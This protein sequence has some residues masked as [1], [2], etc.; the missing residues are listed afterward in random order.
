[1]MFSNFCLSLVPVHT[2]DRSLLEKMQKTHVQL[3]TWEVTQV[4]VFHV[5]KN[6]LVTAQKLFHLIGSVLHDLCAVAY[7]SK[8]LFT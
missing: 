3:T 6:K 7:S 5:V 1:M 4:S 8:Q 2:A